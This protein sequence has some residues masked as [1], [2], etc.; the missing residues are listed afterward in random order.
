MEQHFRDVYP[1]FRKLFPGSFL[2][3]FNFAPECLKFLVEWFAFRKSFRKSGNFSGKILYQMPLFPKCLKFW[4][5]GK[6]FP[7][8]ESC[9]KIKPDVLIEWNGAH[10]KV[11]KFVT[12][13]APFARARESSTKKVSQVKFSFSMVNEVMTQLDWLLEAKALLWP[14]SYPDINFNKFPLNKFPFPNFSSS[15][16]LFP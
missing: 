16:S 1:N 9:R 7:L 11:T 4:I 12:N 15:V 6:R 13:C 2:S 14:I 5:N 8:F 3:A 10:T